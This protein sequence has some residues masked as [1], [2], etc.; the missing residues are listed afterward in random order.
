[1]GSG[2]PQ[3]VAGA[4]TLGGGGPC[5]CVCGVCVCGVGMGSRHPVKVGSVNVIPKLG[6]RPVPQEGGVKDGER[7]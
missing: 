3:V 6:I 4:K 5:A 1:M 7:F 2:E